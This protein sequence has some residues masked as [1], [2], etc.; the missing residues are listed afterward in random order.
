MARDFLCSH[1]LT[2]RNQ[3][4]LAVG[5]VLHFCDVEGKHFAVEVET[6]ERVRVLPAQALGQAQ[7]DDLLNFPVRRAGVRRPVKRGDSLASLDADEF[8]PELGA[9]TIKVLRDDE[10]AEGSIDVERGVFIFHGYRITRRTEKAR[11]F[12]AIV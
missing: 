4:Q 5:F 11:D 9:V 10:G 12:F 7:G 3:D 2:A 1:T 6:R 8:M